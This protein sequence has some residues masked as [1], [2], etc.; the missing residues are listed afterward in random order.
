MR[1]VNSTYGLSIG[2][3]EN[4]INTLVVEK[5]EFMT[6]IVQNIISQINGF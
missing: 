2:F 3:F 4:S 6:D 1:L 5:P